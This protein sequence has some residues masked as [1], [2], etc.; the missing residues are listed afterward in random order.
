MPRPR[1]PL[2]HASVKKPA[3]RDP[4]PFVLD[5]LDALAPATRP[6]F[7]CK[8]VYV[9]PKIVLIL[10]ER[11]PADDDN[12]VWVATEFEHHAS[13]RAQLRSLRSINVFGPGESAWQCIPSDGD[14]FEEEVLR[15]CAMIRAGDPRIGRVPGAK[16]RPSPTTKKAPTKKAPTKKKAR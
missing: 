3:K 10:R 15:V 5:E 11:A 4:F 12:G 8:A 14:R 2:A 9:G 6:M 7:G 1:D 13:L 16:K